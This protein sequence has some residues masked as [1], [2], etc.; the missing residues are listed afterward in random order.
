MK[1]DN[2]SKSIKMKN[3]NNRTI[4]LQTKKNYKNIEK[5]KEFLGIKFLKFLY[6]LKLFLYL[7]FCFY[8]QLDPSRTS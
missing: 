5:H 8:L 2:V 6:I 1:F 3:K 7:H 4:Q